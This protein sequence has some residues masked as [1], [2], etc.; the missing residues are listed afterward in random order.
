[1]IDDKQY[2]ALLDSTLLPLLNGA[3]GGDRAIV[4]VLVAMLSEIRTVREIS[5]DTNSK[6]AKLAAQIE[7][8]GENRD[9][10]SRGPG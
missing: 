6:I 7:K 1:M 4:S 10:S 5:Q 3:T 9:V 2:A 8:A